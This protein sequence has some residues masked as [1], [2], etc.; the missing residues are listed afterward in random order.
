M[1][2]LKLPMICNN[3]NQAINKPNLPPISST[4]NSIKSQNKAGAILI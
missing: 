2:R 3:G 4:S 1:A